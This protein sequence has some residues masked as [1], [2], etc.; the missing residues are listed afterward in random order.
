MI[1][2]SSETTAAMALSSETTA[3]MALSSETIAAINIKTVLT[4]D[5]TTTHDLDVIYHMSYVILCSD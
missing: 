1:T 4:K 5:L 3:A 2:I